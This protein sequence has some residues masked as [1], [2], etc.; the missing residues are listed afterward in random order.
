MKICP[1][2]LATKVLISGDIFNT[3]FVNSNSSVSPFSTNSLMSLFLFKILSI[4][5]LSGNYDGIRVA[6]SES[7]S[8]GVSDFWVES[9][10]EKYYRLESESESEKYSKLESESESAILP[11]ASSM[12]GVGVGVGVGQNRGFLGGVGVGKI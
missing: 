3:A 1:L 7:E 2:P 8:A 11:S 5:S 4:I 12:Q 10:S 9:E 6:E